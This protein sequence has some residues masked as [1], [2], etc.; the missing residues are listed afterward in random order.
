MTKRRHLLCDLDEPSACQVCH[1][2]LCKENSQ[3]AG[4]QPK[5]RTLDREMQELEFNRRV[6]QGNLGITTVDPPRLNW[7]S[8]R[9]KNLADIRKG[10]EGARGKK[11]HVQRSTTK[12]TGTI[13]ISDSKTEE[14]VN[15]LILMSTPRTPCLVRI[16]FIYCRRSLSSQLVPRG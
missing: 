10:F 12:A 16:L 5:P 11:R 1:V 2:V 8:S 13:Q 14:Y 3:K 7:Q 4:L 9:V 15:V 6:E